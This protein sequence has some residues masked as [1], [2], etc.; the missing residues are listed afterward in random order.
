MFEYEIAATRGTGNSWE[1][2]GS[3]YLYSGRI[4]T[5]E[6]NNIAIGF[7][8]LSGEINPEGTMNSPIKRERLGVDLRWYFD[9]YGLLAEYSS[10]KDEGLDAQSTVLEFNTTGKISKGKPFGHFLEDQKL[11]S[12]REIARRSSPYLRCLWNCRSKSS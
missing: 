1:T 4:G 3:P 8:F 10:G 11:N 2:K 6:N 5:Y 12:C 9:N 7:S